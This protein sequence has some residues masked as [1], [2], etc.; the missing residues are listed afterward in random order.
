MI[1]IAATSKNLVIG[2]DN[3]I[4]W[5]SSEDMKFFKETTENNTILVGRKT[6][7]FLPNLKKRNVV[8]MSRTESPSNPPIINTSGLIGR[9][10]NQ[11]WISDNND[12]IVCGGAEIYKMMVPVCDSLFLTVL[13]IEVEGDT[14]F[15]FSFEELDSMFP[16]KN[17]VKPIVDGNIWKYEKSKESKN[18]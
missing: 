14:H 3:T 15:P 7:D 1:A 17:L 4:P 12:I 10:I 2:K 11:Q 6:F 18:I 9:R 8:I 5:K 16:I 13:N